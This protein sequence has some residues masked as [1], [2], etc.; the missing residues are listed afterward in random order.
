MIGFPRAGKG[1]QKGLK[2][3]KKLHVVLQQF[4]AISLPQ[5]SAVFYPDDNFP[6]QCH[7]K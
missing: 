3:T 2:H 7:G 6:G 1:L 4:A 5:E